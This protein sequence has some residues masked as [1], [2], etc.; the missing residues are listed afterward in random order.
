VRRKVFVLRLRFERQHQQL[1]QGGVADLAQIPQPV[2]SQIE[3]GR[4]VPTP[5]ELRR[6]AD[7]LNVVPPED[8]LLDVVVGSSR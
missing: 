5:D 3:R 8:L 2:V 6:L 1:S 7:I 4:V